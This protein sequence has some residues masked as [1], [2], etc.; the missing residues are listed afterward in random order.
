M[1]IYFSQYLTIT[2]STTCSWTHLSHKELH[3]WNPNLS[4]SSNS[5]KGSE[6]NRTA[7]F[8]PVCVPTPHSPVKVKKLL[9]RPRHAL[10]VPEDSD[11]Q[12][13]IHERDKFVKPTRRPPLTPPSPP[14]P[15]RKY[16]WYSIL[17]DAESNP[18]PPCGRLQTAGYFKYQQV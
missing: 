3:K 7:H 10:T 4:P 5:A 1:N 6:R 14:P 17:F 18:W 11:S 15:P 2:T 16:S 13:S 12:I 8:N 9:Y